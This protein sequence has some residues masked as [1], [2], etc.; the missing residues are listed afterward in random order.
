MY[1]DGTGKSGS[2]ASTYFFCIYYVVPST[3]QILRVYSTRTFSNF[4]FGLL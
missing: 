1:R 4:T 2:G 3:V